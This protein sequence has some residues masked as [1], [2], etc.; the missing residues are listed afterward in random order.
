[1]SFSVVIYGID[2]S[3]NTILPIKVDAY[4]LLLSGNY[5]WDGSAW[6][7]NALLWGYSDLKVEQKSI[8]NAIAGFNTLAGTVVPAGEIWHVQAVNGWN[9]TRIIDRIELSAV[10]NGQAMMLTYAQPTIIGRPIIW[11]GQI[12]LNAGDYLLAGYNGCTLNDDLY[13]S[14]SG[15]KQQVNQ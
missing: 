13:L 12:T 15:V 1:M 9:D 8:L 3:T 6:H 10:I 11:T 14:Y 2:L 4:G 7:K 5:G